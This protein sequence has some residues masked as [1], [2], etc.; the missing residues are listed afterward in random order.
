MD[1][2]DNAM[3]LAWQHVNW[4]NF[5]FVEDLWWGDIVA[6]LH[7]SRIMDLWKHLE[8]SLLV[9]GANWSFC[10]ILLWNCRFN[11]SYR[12]CGYY[13]NKYQLY[14]ACRSR[15]PGN[16][17]S[18]IASTS[19]TLP[20]PHSPGLSAQGTVWSLFLFLCYSY[21]IGSVW[22]CI[23]KC[24][25]FLKHFLQG[26]NCTISVLHA[27][28]IRIYLSGRGIVHGCSSPHLLNQTNA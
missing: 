3:V 21:W 7:R 5:A 13:F 28:M 24:A 15:T 12:L 25:C 19:P 26:S 27:I 20:R 11:F 16:R 23:S 6:L 14:F 8:T 17:R 9:L 18:F 10:G 2:W 22:K 1:W 4:P